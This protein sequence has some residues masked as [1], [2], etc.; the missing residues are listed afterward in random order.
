M[1]M[2]ESINASMPCSFSLAALQGFSNILSQESLLAIKM[3]LWK[4]LSSTTCRDFYAHR[5]SF[6][7][8]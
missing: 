4:V 3:P 5:N 2:N 1:S 6:Q 7:D 8:D